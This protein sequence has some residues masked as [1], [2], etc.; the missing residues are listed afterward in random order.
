MGAAVLR[1]D[2]RAE[3]TKVIDAFRDYANA[4]K[5]TL[6]AA[7]PCLSNKPLQ[8]SLKTSTSSCPMNELSHNVEVSQTDTE[9]VS[10]TSK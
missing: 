9:A 6:V 4:Y 10:R 1:A 8:P 2:R 5:K 3:I 7:T